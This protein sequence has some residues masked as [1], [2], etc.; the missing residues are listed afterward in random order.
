MLHGYIGR[1]EA[2]EFPLE[3][4]L[5]DISVIFPLYFLQSIIVSADSL[6]LSL[7]KEQSEM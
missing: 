7:L 4:E 5:S 1:Q 3:R 6:K 2:I